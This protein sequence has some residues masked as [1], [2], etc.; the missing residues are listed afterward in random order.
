LTIV[1]GAFLAAVA[2]GFVFG[3]L[4]LSDTAF[5]AAGL[6]AGAV[7]TA[8]ALGLEMLRQGRPEPPTS[9]TRELRT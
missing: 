7:L 2:V 4:D 9:P 1:L 3:V 8:V 5:L 6:S